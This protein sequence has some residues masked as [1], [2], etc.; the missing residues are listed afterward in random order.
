MPGNCQSPS[1]VPSEAQSMSSI[2]QRRLRSAEN[3]RE[4]GKCGD[5]RA[6]PFPP[7]SLSPRPCPHRR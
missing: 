4:S 3:L 6:S 5:K 7:Q 1:P 2:P